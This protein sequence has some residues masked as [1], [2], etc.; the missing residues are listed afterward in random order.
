[1]GI[2]IAGG[3]GNV[4]EGNF[5]GTDPSGTMAQGNA[6]DGVAISEGSNN[7]IGGTTLRPAT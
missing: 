1:M 2:A 7:R 4:V 6:G 3:S 5:I